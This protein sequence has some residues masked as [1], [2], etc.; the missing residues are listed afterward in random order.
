MEKKI[1]E[2]TVRLKYALMGIE[3]LYRIMALNKQISHDELENTIIIHTKPAT[4]IIKELIKIAE[5]EP[6]KN[7]KSGAG[8]GGGH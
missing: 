2:D 7:Q 8:G 3:S 6:V 5:E 4:K 1:S